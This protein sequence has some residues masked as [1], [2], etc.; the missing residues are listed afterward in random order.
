MCGGSLPTGCTQRERRG[1]TGDAQLSAEFTIHNF[2]MAAIYTKWMRDMR[3]TQ[4][5]THTHTKF[6]YP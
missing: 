5:I 6:E 3:D 4:V 1:W 2:D